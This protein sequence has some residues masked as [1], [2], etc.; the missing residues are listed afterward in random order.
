MPFGFI[1]DAIGGVG[2]FLSG[3]SPS[4]LLGGANVASSLIGANAS[5][6]AA[7][8]QANAANQAAQIQQQMFN[9]QNA[10]QQPYRTAGYSSLNQLLGGLG[11]TQQQFTPTGGMGAPITGTGQFTQTF[12]P[13]QLASNLAP[14]YQF[15]LNQ[16]LGATRQTGNAGGG[17]SNINQAATRFAE[18]YASNAYQNAFANY[19]N[20]QSNIFNRLASI[21]GIGQTAQ[22]QT[23]N[24]ATSTAGNIGQAAIG[25]GQAQAAGQVGVANAL[26]GGLQN[27][28]GYNYLGN[29][30]SPTASSGGGGG[31]YFGGVSTPSNALSYITGE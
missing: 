8:T 18:D 10:Q 22:G 13:Q 9:T 28:A 29:L 11:G 23:Q 26:G 3:L 24:L 25:A 30:L 5:Q 2:S 16:G 17:G 7:Q 27:L 20:Q 15:M 19:Q 14:N 4:T 6:N 1:A 21:A 31:G 12:G